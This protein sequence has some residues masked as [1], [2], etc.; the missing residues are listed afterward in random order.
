M[1]LDRSVSEAGELQGLEQIAVDLTDTDAATRAI[2]DTR[3]DAL[4]HL[5][6][7]AVPFSA[8][9]DVILRTNATMALN[10][11]SAGVAAGI[12]KIVTA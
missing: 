8:P 10:V 7:I 11:M 4:I 9:E 5:A 6:A 1:S 2:A 12:P 3:A